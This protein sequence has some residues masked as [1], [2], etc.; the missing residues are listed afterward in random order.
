MQDYLGSICQDL[1]GFQAGPG[2]TETEHIK[3]QHFHQVCIAETNLKVFYLH[4]LGV[5]VIY[6]ACVQIF[7]LASYSFTEFQEM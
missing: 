1:M 2:V 5:K 3:L 4:N 7:L 6:C